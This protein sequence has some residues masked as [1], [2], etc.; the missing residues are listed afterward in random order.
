M[1]PGW[2]RGT[3]RAKGEIA[4]ANFVGTGQRPASGANN[5]DK[6]G[7]EPVHSATHVLVVSSQLQN[8]LSAGYGTGDSHRQV[9]SFSSHE[10]YGC[11]GINASRTA[12]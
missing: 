2:G 5:K 12:S 8:A 1:L 7:K 10:G 3:G 11:G 4:F 6:S 9:N